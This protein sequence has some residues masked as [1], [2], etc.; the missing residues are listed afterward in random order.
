MLFTNYHGTDN[1]VDLHTAIR[2]VADNIV[3]GPLIC[4]SEALL[5]VIS[6]STKYHSI[7]I[8]GTVNELV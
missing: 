4:W 6:W 8:V 2:L 1:T 3:N 5:A 7:I